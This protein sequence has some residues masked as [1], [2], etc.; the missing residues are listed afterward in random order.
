MGMFGAILGAVHY[1]GLYIQLCTSSEALFTE[2]PHDIMAR[3]GQDVE[4]ACAFRG[5]SSPS[6]SL[7]IQWWYIRNTRDWT[8]KES[9][10]SNQIKPFNHEETRKDATKISAV[11]VVGSNISHNLR[12]SSIKTVDEGTYECRVTDYS[13]GKARHH[14]VKAYLQVKREP[15]QEMKQHGVSGHMQDTKVPANI[16]GDH[17]N[18]IAR[19]NSIPNS[20]HTVQAIKERALDS[21]CEERDLSPHAER[22]HCA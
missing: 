5:S 13:E 10:S 21:D 3:A 18:H 20:P 16:R 8:D 17:T 9:W 2:V 22:I 19:S 15:S 14:K 4:M 1:L 12:L 6:Y 11:K 7:E